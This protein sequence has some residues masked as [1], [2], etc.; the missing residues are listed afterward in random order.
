[1]ACS[2]PSPLVNMVAIALA[3]AGRVHISATQEVR[4]PTCVLHIAAPPLGMVAWPG[5]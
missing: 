5:I 3:Y 2:P 4:L 1:M